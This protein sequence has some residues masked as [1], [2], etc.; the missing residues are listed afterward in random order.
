MMYTSTRWFHPVDWVLRNIAVYLP[1]PKEE[2]AA[3]RRAGAVLLGSDLQEPS[4]LKFSS[5]WWGRLPT[6]APVTIWLLQ[7]DRHVS[8]APCATSQFI[9][10]ST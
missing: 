2:A 9:I 3:I 1:T 4:N 10:S 8:V 5:P 6:I 7:G